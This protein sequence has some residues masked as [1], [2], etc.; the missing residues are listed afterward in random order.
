MGE[1]GSST[2][3]EVCRIERVHA[4]KAPEGL[5]PK[6][7]FPSWVPLGD[8]RAE[9]PTSEQPTP[10]WALN[11]FAKAPCSEVLGTATTKGRN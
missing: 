1:W 11:R 2:P 4:A 9:Y 5:K 10:P 6:R 7:D 8:L 3:S